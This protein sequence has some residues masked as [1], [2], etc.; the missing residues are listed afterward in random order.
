MAETLPTSEWLH[1]AKRVPLGRSDRTYHGRENRPNLVVYNNESEWSAYCHRCHRAGR[2]SKEYVVYGAPADAKA[3][4]LSPPRDAVPVLVPGQFS[5]YDTAVARFL[6]S[7]GVVPSM[8]PPLRYSCTRKRIVLTAGAAILGRDITEM[9]NVKWVQ[10]SG[11]PFV[12]LPG[13][14]RVA[15]LVEDTFSAYKVRRACPDVWVIA[16]LGTRLHPKLKL[17]LTDFAVLVMFDGDAA[18][19]EGAASAKREL[20]GR[21]VAICCAPPGLDPKDMELAHIRAHLENLV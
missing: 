9:S 16:C 2:V 20:P 17:M 8:L 14:K 19:Y 5:E 10:Y 13:C 7:K 1:L 18:G 3:P 4:D 15:V 11:T 21:H 6:V 12:V